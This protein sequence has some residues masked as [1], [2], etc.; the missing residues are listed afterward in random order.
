MAMCLFAM[1]IYMVFSSAVSRVMA[2][3]EG[4]GGVLSQIELMGGMG[5]IVAGVVGFSAWLAASFRTETRSPEVIQALN[6]FGW[7]AFNCT[8]M[9]TTLQQFAVGIVFLSD[10]R[11]RPLIPGWVAYFSFFSGTVFLALSLMTFFNDGP[12]AWHGLI[13]FWVSLGGYFMWVLLLAIYLLS[14]IRRLRD[15]EVR[16]GSAGLAS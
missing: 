11:E 4:Q 13:N 10:K 3:I 14:A 5:T 7:I 2:R 6:D 1:P 9:V 12:F 8:Y 16:H 15:E